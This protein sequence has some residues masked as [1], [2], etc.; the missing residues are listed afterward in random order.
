MRYAAFLLLSAAVSQFALADP[1]NETFESCASG[2]NSQDCYHINEAGNRFNA[3]EDRVLGAETRL[4]TVEAG[5]GGAAIRLDALE[6]AATSADT[7]LG[8]LEAASGSAKCGQVCPLTP[9][10]LLPR[11]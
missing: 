2:G 11:L 8:G 5:A 10:R 6:S 4:D 7:R 3:V 1:D 9:L